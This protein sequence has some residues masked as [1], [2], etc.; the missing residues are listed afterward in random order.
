MERF[1][2][3]DVGA[4]TIKLAELGGYDDGLRLVRHAIVPHGKEPGAR[5]MEVLQAWDWRTVTSVAAT[6]RL[7]RQLAVDRIPTRNALLRGFRFLHGN[8]PATIVSIGSRG[9]CVLEIPAAGEPVY[10]ESSRCAQGTGNFLRQLVGRFSMTVE[11]A[12]LA[13]EAVGEPAPLSGRCPV[14]LKTDMT[15]LA[16]KGERQDR[17]LAGLLDAIAESAEVLVKP[18]RSPPRVLLTGGVTRS[19]RIREHFRKFLERSGMTLVDG[20]LEQ[21]LVIEAVGCAVQ[22]ALTG[23]SA[24]ALGDLL[25]PFEAAKIDTVPALRTALGRVRR[26]PRPAAPAPDGAP[27]DVVLGFDI[28][29]TGS[30]VVA[31]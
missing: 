9:I 13:A 27:R 16:N 23:A 21:S 10:R 12:A 6:G 17:I 19:R 25:R 22:A 5:L 14:I 26:M 1:I 4:E 3:I 28:G 29:S 11:E 2:G 15:H 7:G 24:R 20:D 31:L 30:K 8:D 18:R